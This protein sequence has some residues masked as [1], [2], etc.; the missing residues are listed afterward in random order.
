MGPGLGGGHGR[1]QGLYGL[2]T[3]SIISLNVVLANSSAIMVNSTSNP[4]LFW[5][6][7]GAGHNYGI[8][9]SFQL[10]IHPRLVDTWHYHNYIWTQDKLEQVFETLN[11]FHG[12]GTTP[13]LMGTNAGQF[14]IVPNISETE[15]SDCINIFDIAHLTLS[16]RCLF[17]GLAM[18]VLRLMLRS[19]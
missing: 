11:T 1:Y 3:D 7:R 17:G 19:S 13:V 4:D 8:V 16:R 15:A 5:A 12:N 14:A 10:Q 9:T 18:L 6:M 2:I